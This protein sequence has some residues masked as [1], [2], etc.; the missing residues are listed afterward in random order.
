MQFGN[1]NISSKA[2][3][4]GVFGILGTAKTVSDYRSVGE[5]YKKKILLNDVVVL[6]ASSLGILGYRALSKNKIVR[7]KI[8]R[9]IVN[10]LH[11]GFQKLKETK[12]IKA[13]TPKIS[14]ET[15]QKYYKP[16]NK[17]LAL[18]K[19]VITNCLTSMAEVASG[20]LGAITGD[21]ILS[22]TGQDIHKV[23]DLQNK[24]QE[25]T[26]LHKVENFMNKQVDKVVTTDVREEMMNRVT[27]F[28]T[29]KL[30]WSSFVGLEGLE[31]TDDEKYSHQLKNAS[32]YL[33]LNSFVPLLFLNMTSA[34]SKGMKDVYRLPLMFGALVGGTLCVKKVVDK[35]ERKELAEKF[36]HNKIFSKHNH[37]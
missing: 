11:Q 34:L 24:K 32:K 6:G 30:F 19:V 25:E 22:K 13:I 26:E 18:S 31:I 37:Q 10:E 17:S 36:M 5:K 14:K 21:F 1:Y 35:N 33:M 16:V 20:L 3:E 2:I 15:Q 29:F 8:S 12:F 4:A 7:T 28:S 9:P 27:D 23:K